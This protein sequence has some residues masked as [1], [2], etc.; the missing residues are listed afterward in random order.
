MAK[1]RGRNPKKKAEWVPQVAYNTM[2]RRLSDRISSMSHDMAAAVEYLEEAMAGELEDGGHYAE[3][4]IRQVKE[5]YQHEP[6]FRCSL[7]LWQ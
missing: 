7:E 2:K 3:V 6:G 1:G 5:K 4:F